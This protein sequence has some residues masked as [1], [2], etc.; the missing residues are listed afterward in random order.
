MECRR[1][2]WDGADA[3]G[4]ASTL[5]APA[6][7]KPRLTGE[8]AA[9]IADVRERGDTALAELTERFD[10]PDM[11]VWATR[12]PVD[13][14]ADAAASLDADLVAALDLSARNVEAVAA[15]DLPD[16]VQLALHE[17]Q[18]VALADTPVAAAGVYVPGGRAAYPSSAL[19]GCA[20]ARAAG[21]E[22]IVMVSPP[23]RD[24]TVNPVVLAVA[25]RFG[26]EEVYAVG[27]VQAVAALAIGTDSIN[28]V[29]V[30]VGPGNAWVTEAKRQLYGEVGIDGLAGP[31]EI[32][33]LSDG[34]GEARAIALDLLAQA[35]HGPDSLLAVIATAPALLDELEGLLSELAAE[36]P[37]VVGLRVDLVEAGG[38]D[39]ALELAD[40]VAPEHLELR[41]AEAAAVAPDRVAGCVFVGEGA[42]TAFGDYT[43]GS[44]HILPTGGAARFGAPLSPRAFMRRTAVVDVPAAA[45]AALA[46]A[47]NTIARAEGLPVHGESARARA[48]SD[49]KTDDLQVGS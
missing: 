30:I 12:V 24:G 13:R 9:I 2:N 14:I 25:E 23:G 44:N 7:P 28:P 1:T 8:V 40:A 49:R 27:G 32:V 4:F 21:V 6:A 36:R 45:A 35:E 34:S 26:V 16:P 43:A 15:A 39:V 11:D 22:R 18:S 37:S 10:D 31:S 29:D 5:R 47:T 20:P 3:R 46:E 17:G 19:M 41:I 33:V 42:A 48:A 38:L